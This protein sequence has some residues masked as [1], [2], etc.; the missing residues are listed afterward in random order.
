MT[1]TPFS[2]SLH[3]LQHQ[4]HVLGQS[5]D[6]LHLKRSRLRGA[7]VASAHGSALASAHGSAAIAPAS[8]M[9]SIHIF[10][11]RNQEG[12]VAAVLVCTVARQRRGGRPPQEDHDPPH[13]EPTHRRRSGALL[14]GHGSRHGLARH[15][16]RRGARAAPFL[17]PQPSPRTPDSSPSS[18]HQALIYN[19]HGCKD[20]CLALYGDT[21]AEQ[22]KAR[23]K[24]CAHLY[25]QDA[26]HGKAGYRAATAEEKAEH[27]LEYGYESKETLGKS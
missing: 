13:Q 4:S 5:I 2:T 17:T 19:L 9:I 6:G 7:A 18:L 16:R 21:L 1:G 27:L 20:D 23:R 8:E 25:D 10:S 14:A 22:L 3:Q 11:F 12:F 26:V 24:A 15:E